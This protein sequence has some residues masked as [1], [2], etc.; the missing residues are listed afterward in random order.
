MRVKEEKSKYS[1]E[2][3]YNVVYYQYD[4]NG[5]KVLEKY[6]LD[7]VNEEEICYRC[8]EISF[9]YDKENRLIE[10]SDKYGA[11][12]K[13][14]YDCLN[15]KTFESFKINDDTTQA[16]HYIYDNVG[17]LV[18]R[19]E[20]EYGNKLISTKDARKAINEAYR[21]FDSIGGFD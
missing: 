17:N 1:A 6:G 4:N 8:N 14:R 18:E 7:L 9:K 11:K 16:V 20:E 10:V 5:N 21:Y 13:Y 2:L 12:A 3:R 15:H 19:K